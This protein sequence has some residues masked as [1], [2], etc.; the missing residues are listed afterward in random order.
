MK[1]NL[2]PIILNNSI[3]EITAQKLNYMKARRDLKW[4]PNTD[5]TKGIKKTVEWYKN[6][7]N[8]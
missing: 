3:I 2:K 8:Y 7:Y 4:T 6:N 5:F 1:I